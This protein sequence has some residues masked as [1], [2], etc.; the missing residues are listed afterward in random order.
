MFEPQSWFLFA[1]LIVLFA[2]LIWWLIVAR[3]IALKIVAA[4]S[5]A[6]PLLG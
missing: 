6:P 2:A 4:I 3:R 5:V 1:L